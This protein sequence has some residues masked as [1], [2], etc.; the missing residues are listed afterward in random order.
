VLT[1]WDYHSQPVNRPPQVDDHRPVFE[2]AGFAINHYNETPEWEP[3]QRRI[4]AELLARVDEL[5]AESG[6][7]PEAIRAG[8]MEMD[9]TIDTITRR[10][11]M[12]ATRR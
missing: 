9:A 5:A 12:V 7:D 1:S 4:D 2:A 3:I 10:F 6:E 11:L 8:I